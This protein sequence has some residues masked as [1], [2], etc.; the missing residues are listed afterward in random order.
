[1]IPTWDQCDV[2]FESSWDSLAR[3][4]QKAAARRGGTHWGQMRTAL[5]GT[6]RVL[7]HSPV[8]LHSSHQQRQRT[9][10]TQPRRPGPTHFHFVSRRDARR[11]TPRRGRAESN[12]FENLTAP[13]SRRMTERPTHSP[14]QQPI[15][16]ASG[17]IIEIDGQRYRQRDIGKME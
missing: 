9:H 3:P 14:L 12:S 1:M 4:E 15:V 8:R 6:N 13:I 11:P 5:A 16:S 10:L 7:S 17:L 2:T